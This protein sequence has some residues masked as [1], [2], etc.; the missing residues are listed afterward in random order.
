LVVSRPIMTHKNVDTS[1]ELDRKKDHLDLALRSQTSAMHLDERFYY[2]PA[3]AKHPTPNQKSPIQ[4]LNHQFDF[5]FWVSSMTG[6]TEAA[7]TINSRLSELCAEFNLGMGLGSIRPLLGSSARLKDFDF[8]KTIGERPFYANLGVAQIEELLVKKELSRL[9]DILET[10]QVNGLF[11][12]LNPLQEWFQPE[13]DRYTRSPLETISEYVSLS[14]TKVIVKEVG[15]GLGPASL[16]ALLK[17]DIQGIEFGAFGGTN[18]SLLEQTRVSEREVDELT[19]VGH[20]ALEMVNY[21]NAIPTS[22]EFIISG[23]IKSAIDG[24]YLQEKLKANSVIGLASAWLTPALE[25]YESLKLYF[26]NLNQR[27]LMCEAF[28]KLKE[29]E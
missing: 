19:F 18:F 11:I 15:H 1:G 27:Y 4:F 3:L 23:G 22:K 26:M 14:K 7:Y 8:R 13:G 28:L 29:G 10:L 12:H 25:S 2:E 16:M 20:S 9:E 17:L 24:Y 5:P 6:G 21:I